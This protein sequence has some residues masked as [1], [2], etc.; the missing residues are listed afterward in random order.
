MDY[1]EILTPDLPCEFWS[2]FN[3][4]HRLTLESSRFVKGRVH[5]APEGCDYDYF[6][7]LEHEDGFKWEVRVTDPR[8]GLFC[9]D[10]FFLAAAWYKIEELLEKNREDGVFEFNFEG[11]ELEL[12]PVAAAEPALV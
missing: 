7:L 6:L 3:E 2:V 12:L 5:D 9:A 1:K 11:P 4:H 10:Y 8:M